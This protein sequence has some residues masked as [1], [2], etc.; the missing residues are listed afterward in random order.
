M[1]VEA[2]IEW[3]FCVTL[4]DGHSAVLFAGVKDFSHF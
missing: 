4:T 3:T 2:G 1:Q